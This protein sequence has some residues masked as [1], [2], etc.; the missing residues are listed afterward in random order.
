[1]ENWPDIEARNEARLRPYDSFKYLGSS[2]TDSKC[3]I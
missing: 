2:Q 3:R 1:M